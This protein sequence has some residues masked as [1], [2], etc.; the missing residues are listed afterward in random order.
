AGRLLERR[1]TPGPGVAGPTFERYAYDAPS[2]PL[3]AEND[4]VRV[5]F[6]YDTFGRTILDARDGEAVR[7]V[8]DAA[9]RR[10]E[11][12][13]PGGRR[14]RFGYDGLDRLTSVADAAGRTIAT[15]EYAGRLDKPARVVYGNGVRQDFTYDAA[16][17]VVRATTIDAAG[18]AVADV[19]YTY[20]GEGNVVA[21]VD[22]VSGSRSRYEYD[23]LDRLTAATRTTAAG[24][25]THSFEYDA[26]GNRRVSTVNGVTT[27]Y[28]VGAGLAN[29]YAE[30]DGAQLTYDAN[31]NLLWDGRKSVAYTYDYRD[32]LVGVARPAGSPL[33][34]YT[35]DPF[36]RRVASSIGADVRTWYHDAHHEIEERGP[37]NA[38]A[39]TYV[40][41][42]RLDELLERS[43]GAVRHFLHGDALGSIRAAGASAGRVVGRYDYAP[44]GEA[45]IRD[46]A[47]HPRAASAI[48]NAH[49]F[50]GRRLDGET[51]LYHVRARLLDPSLGG[52]TA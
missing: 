41:G 3:T 4:A 20:D 17:R 49:L 9:G 6:G 5:A 1:I 30:V 52:F 2:R 44:F 32:Q 36:G 13:Y 34:R 29:A 28:R 51:G 16:K 47:G 48:D 24:T 22:S 23:S 45:T 46:P 35:H 15:F 42:A 37:A 12:R 40:H 7:S 11:L 43:Q 39:A 18:A 50:T 25:E 31:G 19:R 21:E 33:A 38:P 10:V 14:V 27:Q 8:Y 26:S